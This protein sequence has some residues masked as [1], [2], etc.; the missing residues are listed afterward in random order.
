MMNSSVINHRDV[1]LSLVWSMGPR[2]PVMSTQDRQHTKHSQ[3]QHDLT[4]AS[5][6]NPT[7]LKDLDQ[8]RPCTRERERSALT[9]VLCLCDEFGRESR[10]HAGSCIPR[11]HLMPALA[12]SELDSGIHSPGHRQIWA[13]T[14]R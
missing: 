1:S 13:W 7:D 5:S 8:D 12:S 14:G 9:R 3:H 10:A 4:T 2:D 6:A 11:L